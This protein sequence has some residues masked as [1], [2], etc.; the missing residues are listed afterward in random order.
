MYILPHVF[1]DICHKHSVSVCFIRNVVYILLECFDLCLVEWCFYFSVW[2]IYGFLRPRQTIYFGNCELSY[3]IHGERACTLEFRI[4]VHVR[5][6]FW[7]KYSRL[8]DLIRVCTAIK[9]AQ[10]DPACTFNLSM[11]L[12]YEYKSICHI[13]TWISNSIDFMIDCAVIQFYT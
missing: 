5:L 6:L 10:F 3:S 13:V 7:E 11:F 8:Y 2:M 4:A 12:S 1:V 9:I